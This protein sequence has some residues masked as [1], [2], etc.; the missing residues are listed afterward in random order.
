MYILIS[1][2]YS[3]S[4]SCEIIVSY[5]IL[6]QIVFSAFIL[7]FSL[8]RM[9]NFNI[10]DDPI[11]FLSLI[12]FAVA[13]TLQIYLPC[14]YANKLT[15]ESSRLMDSI[16]KCN[17]IEMSPYNRKLVLMYMQYLQNSIVLKAGNFFNVGLP[18]FTKV[19]LN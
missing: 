16:Y 7:C 5:P 12:Q 18:I 11:S 3:M 2:I 13:M 10:L 4:K 6:A 1:I 17:W 14:Y 15:I 19:K 8:Y 9:Q